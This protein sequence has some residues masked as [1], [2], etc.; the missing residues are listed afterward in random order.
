MIFPGSVAH[1]PGP[2][3]HA[4]QQKSAVHPPES[5]SSHAAHH[6]S[7]KAEHKKQRRPED[8]HDAR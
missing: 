1:Q 5:V 4:E 8:R 6:Q 2:E 7:E 3:Q